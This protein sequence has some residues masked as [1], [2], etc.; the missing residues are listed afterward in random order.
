[1]A[2][3]A[4]YN[5]AYHDDWAWSLAI[6]GATDEEIADAFD[7]SV[8]TIHRWKKDH[9]TFARALNEGKNIADAKVEKKLYERALGYSVDETEKI[10][11][12]DTKTGET[13]PVR[14]KTTTKHIAPD[15]MAQMYWLNN[16]KRSEWAQRQDVSITPGDDGGDVVI[17]IPDNGRD[18]ND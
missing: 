2:A 9:D 1:M 11:E 6:K 13:K 16:R 14:V 8:R 3:P 4:K 18:K 17:Y 5:S 7:V 10:V 12:V 15:V